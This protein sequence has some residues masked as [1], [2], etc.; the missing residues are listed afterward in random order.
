M[1]AIHGIPRDRPAREPIGC[2]L[3]IGRKGPNGAPIDKHRF[4]VVRPVADARGSAG[5]RDP[6]PAYNEFNRLGPDAGKRDGERTPEG[7]AH[8][9]LRATV[10][11]ILVHGDKHECWTENLQA[12]KLEGHIHPRGGP[13]CVGNGCT[14][15]RWIGGAY[16]PIACPGRRC[17]F[18]Q[19]TT[20]RNGRKARPPCHP[21]VKLIFQLRMKATS[22]LCKFTSNGW[23]SSDS[24]KGFF[25]FIE[26]QARFLG[27]DHVS[28]YG[29]PFALTLASKTG[30]GS[31]YTVA[32]MSPDFPDGRTLQ[33]FL[34]AQ[35]EG[36]KQ[37]AAEVGLLQIGMAA[38]LEDDADNEADDIAALSVPA[39]AK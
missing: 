20:D 17:E 27:V 37:L 21:H 39:V 6:H 14:A 9:E 1:N 29:L 18:M 2:A 8:D 35:S 36:R 25:D 4:F 38:T 12:D 32:H 26:Q 5:K 7:R 3:S 16:V 13:S 22:L 15:E 28:T 10:R 34:H 19:P 24:V 11:G 33:E 31:R 23:E 30:D